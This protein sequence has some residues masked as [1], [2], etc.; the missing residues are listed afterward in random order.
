VF[1]PKLIAGIAGHRLP[2]T[3]A[4]LSRCIEI[5]MR[6]RTREEPISVF[7]HRHVRRDCDPVRLGLV[8]WADERTVLLREAKPALPQRP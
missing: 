6:R 8:E 1:C 3:G 2:L 5:P 4:T 7:S